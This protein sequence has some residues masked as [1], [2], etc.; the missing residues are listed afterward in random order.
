VASV[1]TEGDAEGGTVSVDRRVGARIYARITG[2]LNP[3]L[4]VT[5]LRASFDGSPAGLPGQVRVSY[6]LRNN[7][8]LRLVG[9]PSIRVSG[10]FGLG[11]RRLAGERLAELKPGDT[12]RVSTVVPEVWQ[13]GRLG[14]EVTVSP[15]ASGDQELR[16]PP[17]AAVAS[18]H[19]WVVP[20]LPLAVVVAGA[21]AVVWWRRRARRSTV[22]EPARVS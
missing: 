16:P 14:V 11:E 15:E 9:R 17:A 7:G 4:A 5:D 12:I 3:S 6:V 10:P 19:M 2:T 20:W 13:L 18:A 1:R 8:N 22:S 21:A